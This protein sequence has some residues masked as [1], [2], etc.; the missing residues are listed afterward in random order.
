M[1]AVWE[2][3]ACERKDDESLVDLIRVFVNHSWLI[4]THGN[5]KKSQVLGRRKP[6]M[7]RNRK[8]CQG[9]VE[10]QIGVM[11]S[12]ATVLLFQ[13]SQSQS[14]RISENLIVILTGDDAIPG[15]AQ[16]T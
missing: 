3:S 6:R 9:S 11:Q 14:Q 13:S 1:K 2:E 15:T 12:Y 8:K 5:L 10:A 7:Q 4:W 16:M